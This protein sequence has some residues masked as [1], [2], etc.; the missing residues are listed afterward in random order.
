MKIMEEKVLE[1][2]AWSRSWCRGT[3][4]VGRGL[5]M[6]LS[7]GGALAGGRHGGGRGVVQ[8]RGGILGC[9]AGG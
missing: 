8:W 7:N 9:S 3:Y 4:L 6:A 5:N 2:G 1:E